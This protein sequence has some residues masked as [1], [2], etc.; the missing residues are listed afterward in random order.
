MGS[1]RDHGNRPNGNSKIDFMST[2][3][4]GLPEI[5]WQKDL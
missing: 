1:A 3:L 4:F 2:D 5:F